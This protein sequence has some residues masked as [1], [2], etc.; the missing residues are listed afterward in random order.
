MLEYQEESGK[1]SCWVTYG[2]KNSPYIWPL[3]I[4]GKY[5]PMQIFILR[6]DRHSNK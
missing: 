3:Y 4:Q 5:T 6:L 1:C 2:G